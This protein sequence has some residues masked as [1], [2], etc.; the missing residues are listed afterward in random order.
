MAV[1]GFVL[2][3][4]RPSEPSYKGKPLSYWWNALSQS[5]S[6]D[7]PPGQW[8]ARSIAFTNVIRSIGT[9]AL[10]FYVS[11]LSYKQQT[12]WRN[13]LDDW[14]R[15]KSSGRVQ[16]LQ[17]K[18]RRA[19]GRLCIQ[20]LGPAAAPAI[21][22]LERLLSDEYACDL[23]ASCLAAIGP[24]AF[25]ALSNAV[26]TAREPHVRYATLQALGD[27]GPAAQP[28]LPL[29]LELV[30]TRDPSTGLSVADLALRALVECETNAAA[31]MPL[32][33]PC[34]TDTNTAPGAAYGLAHFGASGVPVLLQAAT[35]HESGKIRAAAVAALDMDFQKYGADRSARFNRFNALF[36]SE[37]MSTSW[38][39][40]SGRKNQRVAA[41]ILRYATAEQEQVRAAATNA[42]NY[43]KSI[44]SNAPPM[45][46]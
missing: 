37:L 35:T 5:A 1:L 38:E 41:V 42:L 46:P 23:A 27:M 13:K 36:N 40:H 7:A 45:P 16:L 19:E 22:A 44:S 34:L 3:A 4:F 39:S 9:N 8:E 14:L 32:L 25:P 43:L 24:A 30:Q 6:D 28:A 2:V 11:C 10:P 29:L 26:A 31:L 17:S 15:S 33:V 18:D 12:S 21:P 20:I